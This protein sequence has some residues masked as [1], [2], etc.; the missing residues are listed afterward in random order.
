MRIEQKAD[1]ALEE[2]RWFEEALDLEQLAR[3]MACSI[4]QKISNDFTLQLY[5]RMSFWRMKFTTTQIDTFKEALTLALW[6]F[7]ERICSTLDLDDA[8]ELAGC[9]NAQALCIVC[10]ALEIAL[11]DA[12]IDMENRFQEYDGLQDV[13][14]VLI[15]ATHHMTG[16]EEKE[17][18][19]EES[20]AE[21]IA[22]YI[23]PYVAD[24]FEMADL[25]IASHASDNDDEDR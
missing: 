2:L 12:R 18:G 10:D 8:K 21:L 1:K 5:D 23:A 25:L 13:T 19:L 3:M 20:D 11:N 24:Y 22:A 14:S 9:V 6:S 15:R 16:L 4:I 17:T 7:H